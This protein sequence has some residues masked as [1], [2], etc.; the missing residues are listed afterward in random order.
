[1]IKKVNVLE[2]LL[3]FYLKIEVE[4]SEEESEDNL[5]FEQLKIKLKEDSEARAMQKEKIQ[6]LI[7]EKKKYKIL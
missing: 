2:H 6:N 7:E 3:V 4:D 5:S 1:M